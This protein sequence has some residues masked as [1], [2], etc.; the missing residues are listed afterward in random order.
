LSPA[1][2]LIV[3]AA[4]LL[5]CIHP[6]VLLVFPHS[7]SRADIMIHLPYLILGGP[8]PLHWA[9]RHFM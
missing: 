8:S 9:N 2:L 6:F 5:T 1:P 4:S 7:L 3:P